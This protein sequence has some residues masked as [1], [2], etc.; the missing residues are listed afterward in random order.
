MYQ[1]NDVLSIHCALPFILV[2]VENVYGRLLEAWWQIPESI[3][4]MLFHLR[5]ER[6]EGSEV[7]HLVKPSQ[8]T[9]Q[10]RKQRYT[11]EVTSPGAFREELQTGLSPTQ[12]C[13]IRRRLA[14]GVFR[15]RSSQKGAK[16][17]WKQE[18]QPPETLWAQ[19]PQ[20]SHPSPDLSPAE[21]PF[22]PDQHVMP[23]QRPDL[24]PHV[25]ALLGP[26]GR[27]ARVIQP[28]WLLW[29]LQVGNIHYQ[30]ILGG[31][32]KLYRW[33]MAA[34]KL[35]KGLPGNPLRV[36]VS[37]E[38]LGSC[39]IFMWNETTAWVLVV[40]SDVSSVHEDNLS[41]VIGLRNVRW[42]IHKS[43]WFSTFVKWIPG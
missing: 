43:V 8:K 25:K 38:G 2:H 41:Q 4:S 19:L 28:L 30:P 15:N 33:I 7:E 29:H 11:G 22:S 34:Q 3:K 17:C 24:W 26:P 37:P 23:A 18:N 31:Q 5:K 20:L 12:T 6:K 35:H 42:N 9:Q 39:T 1:V 16:P 32:G 14:Q 13:S 21:A 10:G 36:G 27:R 40:S